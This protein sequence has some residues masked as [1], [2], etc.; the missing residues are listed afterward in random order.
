MKAAKKR[1]FSVI[2]AIGSIMLM[3]TAVLSWNCAFAEEAPS[4]NLICRRDDTILVG[5]EWRIYRVGKM[6]G[7]ELV[8][9]G[10]FAKYSVSLGELTADENMKAAKTLESYAVAD[11]IPILKNGK[12]DSKGELKFNGLETGVYLAAG[13][14]LISGE[15]IYVPSTFLI[16]IAEE[17][18]ELSYDAYPKFI[19][20]STNDFYNKYAVKKVWKGDESALADRPV[21]IDVEIYCDGSLYDTIKLNSENNWQYSWLSEKDKKNW[22]VVE[23]NIPSEYTVA[24]DHNETQFI[25]ENT[26]KKS[27]TPPVTT[28]VSK[29]KIP[30]TGQ[31]WWPVIPMVGGGVVMIGI[32]AFLRPKKDEE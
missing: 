15:V 8:L 5:M 12:T 18:A 1:I 27:T 32:G 11:N 17:N 29:E 21:E 14:N 30:Q 6:Q 19:M 3:L 13:T 22:S 4:L 25:I 16:N 10:D 20:R 24:I 26:Y 9:E 28:T 7:K 23:R 31:L 2:A